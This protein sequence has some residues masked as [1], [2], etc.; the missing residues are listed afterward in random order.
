MIFHHIFHENTLELQAATECYHLR[1]TRD[2]GSQS[3]YFKNSLQI[4]K[5]SQTMVLSPV[6]KRDRS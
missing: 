1:S 6:R 4:M 2:Q 5:S 3:S